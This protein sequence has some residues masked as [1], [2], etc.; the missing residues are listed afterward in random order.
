MAP[1]KHVGSLASESHF[2][3]VWPQVVQSHMWC[4]AAVHASV[5]LCYTRQSLDMSVYVRVCVWERESSHDQLRSDRLLLLL[6]DTIKFAHLCRRFGETLFYCITIYTPCLPARLCSAQ[7][8]VAVLLI[9]FS[10]LNLTQLKLPGVICRSALSQGWLA[11][12]TGGILASC[13]VIHV[14]Q[15]PSYNLW[16]VVH[17]YGL[18]DRGPVFGGFTAPDYVI[19]T[20]THKKKK[21]CVQLLVYA[22]AANVIGV[23]R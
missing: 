6:K 5:L 7:T 10:C 19:H 8:L 18:D 9:Y 20:H 3:P 13:D 17:A 23:K 14:L 15:N 21:C 22:D 4:S 11:T 2:V 16:P 1:L 12:C